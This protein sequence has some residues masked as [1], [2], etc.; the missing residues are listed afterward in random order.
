MIQLE[1]FL[2]RHQGHDLIFGR[3]SDLM[4]TSDGKDFEREDTIIGFRSADSMTR[5]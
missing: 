4:E 5:G 1:K 3:G 2:F